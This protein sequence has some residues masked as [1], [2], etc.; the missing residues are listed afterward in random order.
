[1]R[2]APGLAEERDEAEEGQGEVC[3]EVGARCRAHSCAEQREWVC[4]R[5]GTR[6]PVSA[7][8]CG[9]GHVQN[10][11]VAWPIGVLGGRA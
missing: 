4:V 6:M 7:S 9:V 10:G 1:M 11:A 3:V 5:A 2:L 8:L